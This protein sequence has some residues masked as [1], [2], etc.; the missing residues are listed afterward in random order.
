MWVSCPSSFIIHWIHVDMWIEKNIYIWDA[1]MREGKW[2][3][4]SCS[5]VKLKVKRRG[6]RAHNSKKKE[7]SF[8]NK[9]WERKLRKMKRQCGRSWRSM[10]KTE[11]GDSRL[12]IFFFLFF[13]HEPCPSRVLAMSGHFK[14]KRLQH[15]CSHVTHVS[16]VQY[17]SDTST[18]LK[19]PC[20]CFPAS[21]L[22]LHPRLMNPPP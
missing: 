1:W 18:A 5:K 7:I 9:K 20:P 4:A 3:T 21:G 16:C 10:R 17:M 12:H 6:S 2:L 15:A 11:D 19:M 14:K 8:E 22:R 13:Q